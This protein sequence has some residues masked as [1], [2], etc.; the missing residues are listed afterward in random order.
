[1]RFTVRT[2]ATLLLLLTGL[3]ALAQDGRVDVTLTHMGTDNLGKRLALALRNQ[4]ATSKRINLVKTSD[5]RIGVYLATMANGQSTVYSATWTLG[6]MADDGYL[7]SRVGICRADAI[8]ACAR[9]LLAETDKH[10]NVLYSVHHQVPA[11]R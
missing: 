8:W 5:E 2:A 9:T 7:T 4:L 11:A 10:A 6:G 3:G 1:M